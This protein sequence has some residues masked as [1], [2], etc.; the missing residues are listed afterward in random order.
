MSA[1]G[2]RAGAESHWAALGEA[3]LSAGLWLLWFVHRL[4]GRWG[5]RVLLAPAIV[6]FVAVRPVARRASIDYLLRV[7]ALPEGATRPRRWLAATRHFASFAEIVL[8]K[9]LV[10]G[11]GLDVAGAPVDVDPRFVEAVAARRGGVLVVAHVGNLE[12]LRAFGRRLPSLRLNVLVHSANSTRFVRMLERLDARS[13]LDLLQVTEVDAAMAAML[14]ERVARGEWVVI[15][16]DRVPVGAG[17]RTVT[18]PFLGAPAAFPVGPW[19]LARALGGPVYWLSCLKHGD[20]YRLRCEHF[21][22][23]IVLPRDGRERAIAEVVGRYATRLEATC[24]LAP[25]Q[26]F[27]FYP[28]W[29]R[30]GDAG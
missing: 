7:G 14:A 21:A 29:E 13:A 5:F 8:D 11:G 1:L 16:A 17:G 27:N 10:W 19:V 3:G 25:Y 12:A 4:L 30:R 24:R 26:W 2:A 23:A 15:A 28:F 22:D 9:A 6:W 18:V 20:G